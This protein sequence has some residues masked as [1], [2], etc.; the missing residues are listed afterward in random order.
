MDEMIKTGKLDK[1]YNGI[2]DCCNRVMKEEGVKS[3]WKGNF[4]NVIRYFPT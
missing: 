3:L 4:T 2:A 1:P